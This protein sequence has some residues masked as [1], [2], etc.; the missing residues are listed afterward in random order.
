METEELIEAATCLN[1]AIDLD[2]RNPDFYLLRAEVLEMLHLEESA[3]TDYKKF[4]ALSP[5]FSLKYE[6]EIKRL[7]DFG[8]YE[9][10][11]K[12]RNFVRKIK[13]I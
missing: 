7:E 9:D 3:K 13:N 11:L 10:G 2:D 6:A 12:L 1:K 5:D 4:K 8:F